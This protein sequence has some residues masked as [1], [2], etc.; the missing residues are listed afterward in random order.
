MISTSLFAPTADLER[1]SRIKLGKAGAGA[2]LQAKRLREEG[3]PCRVVGREVI[4]MADD[5]RAWVRGHNAQPAA[6][7]P[8]WA[9]VN[10]KIPRS[11][12]G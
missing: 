2:M 8:N 9:A 5:L 1:I 3:I 7:A 10:A 11:Q 4:A 6:N 12:A